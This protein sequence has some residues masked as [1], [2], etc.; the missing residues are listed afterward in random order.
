MKGKQGLSQR[1]I[2]PSYRKDIIFSLLDV[3]M[4]LMFFL[5]VFKGQSH[6]IDRANVEMT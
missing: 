6:E 5:L 4:G 1:Q 2:L 3:Q